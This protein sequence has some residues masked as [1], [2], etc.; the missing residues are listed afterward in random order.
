MKIDGDKFDFVENPD[1]LKKVLAQ[2][3]NELA[4]RGVVEK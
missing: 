1:D 4:S 3:D 2:I